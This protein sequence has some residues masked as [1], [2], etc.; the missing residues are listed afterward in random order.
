MAAAYDLIWQL[1]KEPPTLTAGWAA[2]GLQ[3]S[4]NE[5]HKAIAKAEAEGGVAPRTEPSVRLSG[6]DGSAGVGAHSLVRSEL[7]EH[8]RGLFAKD[9][10]AVT[11]R[12]L[13]DKK[14]TKEALQATITKAFSFYHIPAVGQ[15]WRFCAHLAYV[16]VNTGLLGT[17][18]SPAQ[19]AVM[20]A[21]TSGGLDG[22]LPTPSSWE[23]AWVVFSVGSVI[24][25]Q[26]IRMK[27]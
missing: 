25:K 17:M 23:I 27:A 1:L 3:V 14:E 18:E 10:S 8:M 6:A 21:D 22:H 26:H 4:S 19:L 7:R 20:K 13:R 12:R 5:K 15:L 11:V 2:P 16:I 9:Q 24:D